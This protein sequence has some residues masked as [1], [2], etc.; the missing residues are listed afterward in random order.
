MEDNILVLGPIRFNPARHEVE[1]NDKKVRLTPTESIALEVLATHANT[2]CTTSQ[3]VS[4][5]WGY[6]EVGDTGLVKTHIHHLRQKIEPDP[7]NPVYLVT[8]PDEGYKLVI[9]TE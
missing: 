2:V 9:P 3:L 1:C 5:V 7:S 4:E 8:V 6:S